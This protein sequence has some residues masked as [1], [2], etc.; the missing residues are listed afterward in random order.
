MLASS[1]E[2]LYLLWVKQLQLNY[3]LSFSLSYGHFHLAELA[4][5]EKQNARNAVCI[6]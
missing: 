5:E 4:R 6:L 2:T 3:F 1:V